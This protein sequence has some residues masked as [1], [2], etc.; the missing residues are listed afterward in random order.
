[1]H[2]QIL[3]R[4][5]FAM[6]VDQVDLVECEDGKSVM[7]HAYVATGD[8]LCLTFPK[9]F[10]FDAAHCRAVLMQPRTVH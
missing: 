10:P 3:E 4:F 5:G 8:V 9:P 6:P 2:M 1:M 7:A